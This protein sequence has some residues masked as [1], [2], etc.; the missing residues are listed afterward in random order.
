M[1]SEKV[2]AL[3]REISAASA[4]LLK[5]TGER[6]QRIS[7]EEGTV[8]MFGP[9]VEDPG[10]TLL[11]IGTDIESVPKGLVRKKL[12]GEYYHEGIKYQVLG[13][14]EKNIIVNASTG[15][16]VCITQQNFFQLLVAA[17]LIQ[18][19]QG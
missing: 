3:C 4:E 2:Q 7:T 19:T 18:R 9:G 5:E 15:K 1:D 17:G 16:G 10:T 8:L 12:V 13:D 6:M 14:A 11:G